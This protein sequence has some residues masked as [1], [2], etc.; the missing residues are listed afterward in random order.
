[1]KPLTVL[2]SLYTSDYTQMMKGYFCR[3]YLQQI[4]LY[5]DKSKN[6]FVHVP[7]E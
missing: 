5:F 6:I 2:F 1:M 3:K 4:Y 7:E